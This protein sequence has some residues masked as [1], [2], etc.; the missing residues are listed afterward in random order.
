LRLGVGG[1]A[2]EE[3]AYR[4]DVTLVVVVDGD[5]VRHG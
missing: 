3:T 4:T 5:E 2:A 1:Q